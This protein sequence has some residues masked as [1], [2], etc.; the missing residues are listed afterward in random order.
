MSKQCG[1]CGAVAN[2][3]DRVCGNCGTPFAPAPAMQNQYAPNNTP[4]YGAPGPYAPP[5]DPLADGQKKPAGKKPNLG[6]LKARVREM[7]KKQ[8]LT[9]G[10]T[11]AAIVIVLIVLISLVGGSGAKSAMKKYMSAIQ[12]DKPGKMASVLYV[13]HGQDA[14]DYAEDRV[15]NERK[16]CDKIKFEILD[17]EKLKKKELEDLKDRLHDE[18]F[19]DTDK[20]KSAATVAVKT[21]K[22]DG[23]EKDVEFDT[24]TVVKLKGKWKVVSYSYY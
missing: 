15:E 17:V 19:D 8:L 3:F 7:K 18:G 9:Y 16:H 23:S 5:V 4:N 11:C 12:K 2:D 6:A 21:V 20:I 24:Y 10:G 22:K 1:N 13:R 14:D